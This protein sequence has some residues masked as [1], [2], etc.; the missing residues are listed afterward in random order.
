MKI[1]P[2]KVVAMDYTLHLDSGEMVDSSEGRAPL[3]FVFG[4]GE[5][6][7]GLERELEGLE[8]GVE[9][10]I[11]LPPKD[12]YG[13]RNPA[14]I[15]V[16]PVDRFP[17]EIELEVGMI[18][19]AKGPDGQTLPFRVVEIKEGLVTI[20]FNH[21]LAGENLHFHVKIRGVREATAEELLRRFQ[22]R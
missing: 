4:T 5:I 15:L 11:T 1:G 19:Y 18:L 14:M 8:A 17:Q 10:K 16:L 7:V 21:P 2:K 3:E 20:D 6:I 12:G 13:E 22:E 9:K